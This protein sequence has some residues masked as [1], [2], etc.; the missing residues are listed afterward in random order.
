MTFQKRWGLVKFFQEKYKIFPILD[1]YFLPLWLMPFL[2]NLSNCLIFR[3][4]KNISCFY[5]KL[6]SAYFTF[7]I[8]IYDIQKTIRHLVEK[9]QVIAIIHLKIFILFD[10]C[11][12]YG[13]FF[14]SIYYPLP[15]KHR[16]LHHKKT[17]SFSSRCL[18]QNFLYHLFG[19][20]IPS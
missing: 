3:N 4:L 18:S 8:T 12:T 13:F 19:S 11:Q 2:I 7:Y 16:L 9:S 15:T 20:L 10:D 14:A 1:I 6:Y 17:A 5:I